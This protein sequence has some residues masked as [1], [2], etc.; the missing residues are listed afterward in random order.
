MLMTKMH[1]D[2]VD[3]DAGLVHWLLLVQFPHWADL[4]IERLPSG[5]PSTRSTGSVMS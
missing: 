4:P 1:S 5:G 3:I 2:E